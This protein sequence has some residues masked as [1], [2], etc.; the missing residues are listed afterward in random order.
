ME[1]INLPLSNSDKLW[2]VNE[3]AAY[4][5][6]T[7]R[8]VHNLIRTGLP[9]LYLGRLLRFDGEEIRGHLLK[10]RRIGPVA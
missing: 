2:T 8:H 9:H 10:K 1:N 3:V 7:V 6:C 4:F 5:G